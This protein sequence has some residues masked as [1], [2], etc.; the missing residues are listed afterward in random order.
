MPNGSKHHHKRTTCRL[1]EGKN[2]DLKVPI[3]ASPLGGAFVTEAR[4]TERQ[5][6]YPLDMYQCG[7]CGHVQLLDVVDPEVIFAD[8]TY[9]SGRTSLVEHFRRLADGIIRV[10]QLQRSAFVVDVG[11]NDGAFL[12]FFQDCGMKVLGVDAAR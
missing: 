1:C 12:T 6:V 8:Y 4:L 2:L 3:V 5:E 7:D 9:F 10:E 11:S